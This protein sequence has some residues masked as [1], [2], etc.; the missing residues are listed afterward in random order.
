MSLCMICPK[1]GMCCQQ[2]C[3][4]GGSFPK[5]D[6]EVIEQA[7]LEFEIMNDFLLI[8]KDESAP[9]VIEHL[10]FIPFYR[11]KEPHPAWRVF[12]PKID[13][14]SGRCNDYENRPTACRVY[15]PGDDAMCFFHDPDV[16][17]A[18]KFQRESRELFALSE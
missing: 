4:N 9:G 1:P 15:Q 16:D 10:P 12:C 6:N 13:I 11:T 7:S 5:P 17:A 3:L 8:Q 2:F 14:K 18:A